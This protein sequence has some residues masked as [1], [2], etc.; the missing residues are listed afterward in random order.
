VTGET[1]N[2][3]YPFIEGSETDAGSLLDDLA[4]S[5]RGKWSQSAQL[6]TATLEAHEPALARAAELMAERFAAGGRLFTFGNGGSA[7]DAEGVAQ[8]YTRPPA[9]GMPLAARSLVEDQAVI[10]ALANDVG[11]DNVFSRQLIAHG[12]RGDIAMGFS[13]S[14]NSENLLAAF[15]QARRQGLLTVGLSGYRGGRMAEPDSA[16]ELCFVVGSDSV[17]R[18]QE[19]Q[20]AV[21]HALWREVQA[22]LASPGAGADRAE[23]PGPEIAADPP[24]GGGEEEPA[25]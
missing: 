11:F 4:R 8:L 9:A 6:R 2:F 1:T 22:R 19:A 23:R 13:T 21:T 10:T 7:T 16:V 3:L 20:A 25:A 15:A 24:P 5:A 18:I 12:Q 14:G 17:H